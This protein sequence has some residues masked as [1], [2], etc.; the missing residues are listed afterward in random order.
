M[1]N[2]TDLTIGKLAKQA[3]VNV[4]TI[5][6]YQR[7]NLIL[8]PEKP[9]SGYRLYP[10]DD[11]ARVNFIKRAQQLGFTLKEIRELLALGEKHCQE[12]QALANDKLKKIEQ[13]MKDLKAMRSALKVLLTQCETND[14]SNVSCAIIESLSR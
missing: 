14:D 1:V 8:E 7:M 13:R 6:Y 9:I 10:S 3:N 12:I 5:R 2:K 4:E 11:I